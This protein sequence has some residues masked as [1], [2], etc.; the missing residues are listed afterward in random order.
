MHCLIEHKT[1]AEMDPKCRAGIEHHQLVS[2]K[3][4]R[5][6]PF[7]RLHEIASIFLTFDTKNVFCKTINNRSSNKTL[8]KTTWLSE[9]FYQDHLPVREHFSKSF[10][11]VFMHGL[12][13]V[14]CKLTT[15]FKLEVLKCLHHSI[16]FGPFFFKNFW[17]LSENGKQLK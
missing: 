15:V 4:Y 13:L 3:D 17:S 2:L 11:T 9:H 16:L 8:L 12:Q 14:F 10:T 5:S 6:H 1:K 7:W